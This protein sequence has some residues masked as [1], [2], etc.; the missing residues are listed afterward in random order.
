MGAGGGGEEGPMW[1]GRAGG[2]NYCVQDGL[3]DELYT[4]GIEPI[5]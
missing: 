4:Q 2:I 1:G 5:F 3:K